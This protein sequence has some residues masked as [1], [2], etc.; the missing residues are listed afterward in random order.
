MY[1]NI[2]NK[3]NKQVCFLRTIVEIEGSNQKKCGLGT[4]NFMK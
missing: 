4:L 3:D 1:E 2:A